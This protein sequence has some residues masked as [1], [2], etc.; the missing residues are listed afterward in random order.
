MV[1]N[2]ANHVEYYLFDY[3]W[4]LDKEGKMEKEGQNQ[5]GGIVMTVSVKKCKICGKPFKGEGSIGPTCEE[6][7]GE[8]GKYY[9]QKEGFPHPDEYISLSQLCD[10]AESLGKSRYWMVKLTGGDGGVKPPYSPEFTIYI[11]GKIK[12]CKRICIP[13]IRELARM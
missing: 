3:G 7:M 1:Q 5:T 12:Y 11:F 13:T 9:I 8:L 4:I 6:H 2:L 10:L